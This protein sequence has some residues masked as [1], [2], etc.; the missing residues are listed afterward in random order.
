[1]IPRSLIWGVGKYVAIAAAAALFYLKI[2]S[3]AF[4]RGFAKRDTEAREVIARLEQRL[5]QRMKENEG[6]TDPEIDCQLRRLRNPKA[7]CPK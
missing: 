1:M 3:D 4:D 2:T 7:E 5:A 6:L